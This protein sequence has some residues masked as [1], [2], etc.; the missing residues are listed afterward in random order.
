MDFKILLRLLVL[1]PT[2]SWACISVVKK[3]KADAVTAINDCATYSLTSAIDYLYNKDI[4]VIVFI[5]WRQSPTPS[6][7]LQA[8]SYPQFLKS[9]S[10]NF[11]FSNEIVSVFCGGAGDAF[12]KV[13]GA[14][15]E[16][17]PGVLLQWC[18]RKRPNL[19]SKVEEFEKMFQR[20]MFDISEPLFHSWLSLKFAVVQSRGDDVRTNMAI[21]DTRKHQ[22]CC[23]SFFCLS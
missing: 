5:R 12:E 21:P 13:W 6:A 15:Y 8:S 17:C 16:P 14:S 9:A 2:S 18:L 7:T 23:F 4:K 10:L 19:K 11:R 1:L 22:N 20:R 3:T